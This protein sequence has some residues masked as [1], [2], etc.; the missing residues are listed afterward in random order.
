MHQRDSRPLRVNGAVEVSIGRLGTSG[1][2]TRVSM[3]I[4]KAVEVAD[5]NET[6]GVEQDRGRGPRSNKPT[7]RDHCPPDEPMLRQCYRAP[8]CE[9][10]S[11]RREDAESVAKNASDL[12]SDSVFYSGSKAEQWLSDMAAIPIHSSLR[13]GGGTSP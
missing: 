8:T 13:V 7:G 4:R 11:V 10:S 1:R 2:S 12:G 5:R 6:L 3:C 9:G